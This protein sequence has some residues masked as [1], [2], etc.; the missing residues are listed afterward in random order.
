M[1]FSLKF[2]IPPKIVI[3]PLKKN[4]ILIPSPFIIICKILFIVTTI[5]KKFS[6]ILEPENF[7]SLVLID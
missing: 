6:I 3:S 4:K 7:Y 1:G 2:A 5:L